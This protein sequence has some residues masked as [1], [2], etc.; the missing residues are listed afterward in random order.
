MAEGQSEVGTTNPSCFS[1]SIIQVPNNDPLNGPRFIFIWSV[2]QRSLPIMPVLA[3][4]PSRPSDTCI[5]HIY[6]I[7]NHFSHVAILLR[8]LHPE[9]V[10][11]TTP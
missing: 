5:N 8:L 4:H 9:D 10:S 2:S 1:S 6:V 3:S 7:Q 11:T